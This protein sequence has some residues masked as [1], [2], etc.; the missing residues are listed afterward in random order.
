MKKQI[1]IILL[2]LF[3]ANVL[4]SKTIQESDPER[5]LDLSTFHDLTNTALRVSNYGFIGSGDDLGDPNPSLEWPYNFGNSSSQI[6]YLYQGALWIGAKKY[7]RNSEGVK[8]YWLYD[9]SVNC[10]D[11]V[12]EGDTDNGWTPDLQVIVD[13]LVTV[14]FDGDADTYEFLPAYNPLE[15]SALGEQYQEYNSQ[16]EVLKANKCLA[17]ND[18]DGDGLFDEDPLGSPFDLDDP[19]NIYCFTIPDD[20]DGDGLFDEDSRFPGYQTTLSY[21]YDYSPFGTPGNRYWG[22]TGTDHVPLNIAIAQDTYSWPVQYYADMIIMKHRIYNTSEVDTL[23]DVSSGFFMDTDIGPSYWNNVYTDDISSFVGEPYNFAYAYDEDTD[24]GLTP[25]FVGM[26]ILNDEYENFTC[27][28]WEVGNGPDDADPLNY[29][30]P[31][32]MTANEKYW[33]LTDRNPSEAEYTSLKDFPDTQV[34]NPVDTRFL[35]SVYGDMNGFDEPTENSVNI[36]PGDFLDLYTAIFLSYSVAGLQDLSERAD[37]LYASDFNSDAMDGLPSFTYLIEVQNFGIESVKLNWDNVTAPD[38]LYVCYKQFDAPAIDWEYIEVENN[39]SEYILSGLEDGE[40]YKFKIASE[41]GDVYLESNVMSLLVGLD[42]VW[43][44]DTDNNGIVELE[45]ILPIGVYWRDQGEFRES[46]SYNWQSFGYPYI[47]NTEDAAYADCNGDGEV[48]ISDVLAICLNFGKN[49][50]LDY[51]DGNVLPDDLTAY[52]D[53]FFAVYNSFD[54]SELQI[55]LKN[56]L[57][58]KFDFPVVEAEVTNVLLNNFPNPFNP[59]T[60]INFTLTAEDAKNA[61]LIIYN[62]KGQVVKTFSENYRDE[63]DAGFV[64]WSGDDNTETKVAS[65]IY[66]YKLNIDNQIVDTKKMILIK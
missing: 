9:P 11:T 31:W 13:T 30:V 3:V 59:S 63:F 37:E 25:G 29:D 12:A 8:L 5:K 55:E 32:S 15:T 28:T 60:T 57:A 23:Y 7:R 24:D 34:G 10:D 16:D 49:S 22:D 40:M 45:D 66:F 46:V 36:N 52:K 20:E 43:P 48:N 14:G 17:N 56:F 61:E 50:S 33:L 41:F 38:E 18:E 62:I 27:W 58:E 35:Y 21:Y 65:G 44:G 2:V 26:K 47:W 4:I 1:I 19:L 39:S 42:P 53:N 6:N 54:N 64:V 51:S